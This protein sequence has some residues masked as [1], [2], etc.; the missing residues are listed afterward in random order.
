MASFLADLEALINCYSLENASDTPDCVAAYL[1]DVLALWNMALAQY[2]QR[3]DHR[4]PVILWNTGMYLHLSPTPIA[5]QRGT[6]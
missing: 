1:Y 6:L 3:Q 5:P 4:Q 2:R